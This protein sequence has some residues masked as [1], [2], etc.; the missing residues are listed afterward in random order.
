MIG[1]VEPGDLIEIDIPART[2]RLQVNEEVL[3]IRKKEHVPPTPKARS[4]YLARYAA[5]VT[6]A[7]T[8]AVLRVPS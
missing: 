7:D 4:G 6:S 5:M 1:L 2:I 3:A 8:G